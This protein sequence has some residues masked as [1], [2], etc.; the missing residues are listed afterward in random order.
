MLTKQDLTAFDKLMTKRLS[1]QDKRFDQKLDQRFAAQDKR[2]DAKFVAQDKR[3]DAKFVNQD[4]HLE[5]LKDQ[6][7][8]DITYMLQQSVINILCEHDKRL[9]RLEKHVGGF[10]T[11]AS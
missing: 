7:V 9:D 5:S 11:I 10:P 1:E 4:K 2:I 8:K 3:I 6:I